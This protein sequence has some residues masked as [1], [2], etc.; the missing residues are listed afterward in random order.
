MLLNKQLA[1]KSAK[2]SYFARRIKS[3]KKPMTIETKMRL[4]HELLAVQKLF[5]K[6]SEAQGEACGD[7][8]DWHDNSTYE[9]A[10]RQTELYATKLMQIKKLLTN[11]IINQPRLP[12]DIVGIGNKLLLRINSKIMEVTLLTEEDSMTRE[13]WLS[14]DSP[15][16]K[17]ILNKPIGKYDNIEIIKILP[18]N[19]K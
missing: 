14:C 1:H 8:C 11:P 9:F 13:E 3:P 6:F 10:T 19:F 16:G 7:N 4:E 5:K 18:G 2:L 12:T 15:I 17:L